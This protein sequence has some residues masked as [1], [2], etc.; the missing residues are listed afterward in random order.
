[1]GASPSSQ[2]TTTS[3][4]GIHSLIRLLRVERGM[5]SNVMLGLVAMGH[6]LLARDS[7]RNDAPQSFGR[8]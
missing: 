3:S 2:R 6:F 4:F 7:D 8:P 1:M 5:E